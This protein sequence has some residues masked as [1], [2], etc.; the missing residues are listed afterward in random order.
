MPTPITGAFRLHAIDMGGTVEDLGP[1]W[2]NDILAVID[3]S[4]TLYARDG[5]CPPWVCYLVKEDGIIVGGGAF[6]G[7]PN[8]G[9]V[10]IAYFTLPELENRGFGTRTARA[11]IA[12]AIRTDEE[13][14]ITAKTPPRP[15]ASTRILECLGF[16]REGPTLDHEIGEAWLWALK[17]EHRAELVL[18]DDRD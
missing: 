18:D 13:I 16:D 10:E 9:A 6:V 11:L 12:L 4:R 5:H 1:P 17:P 8:D 3:M 2:P 15:C 14:A 7:P